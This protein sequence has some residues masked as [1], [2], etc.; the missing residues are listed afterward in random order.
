MVCD[1]SV[2]SQ[3]A[4]YCINRMSDEVS[5]M[6]GNYLFSIQKVIEKTKK[7]LPLQVFEND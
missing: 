3:L 4:S 2:Y 1:A 5:M 6:S 7:T